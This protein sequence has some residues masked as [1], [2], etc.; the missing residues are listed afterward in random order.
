MKKVLAALDESVAVTPVLRTASALGD[1]LGAEVEAVHVQTN[2]AQTPQRTAEAVG[3]PLRLL[4]GDVVEQLVQ[5]CEDPDVVALVIG[6]RGLRPQ[7]RPLGATA[8][9]VAT[10]VSKPVAIV[11]PDAMPPTAL[12]RVLVP[13]EEDVSSALAPL[14]LIELARGKE[15]EVVALHVFGFDEIP[16]FTDQPQHEQAAWARE[17]VARYCPWGI[18]ALRLE[19][20]VG[21]PEELVPRVAEECACDVVALGWAQQVAPGRAPVVRAALERSHL[22]VILV[23]V[24][25]TDASL[26]GSSVVPAEV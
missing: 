23:P 14:S 25:V 8:R 3:V 9:A 17:F 1:L 2:G 20:R 16:A 12:G 21:R 5:A 10:S 7:R 15:L 4:A 11:P 22:P 26:A 24:H 6:A 19:T 13:L 18:G